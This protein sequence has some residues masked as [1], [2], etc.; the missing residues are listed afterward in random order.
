M[1]I[2]SGV[3]VPVALAKTL[4][5]WRRGVVTALAIWS[6]SLA[7]VATAGV[8]VSSDAQV[9]SSS[10]A[11]ALRDGVLVVLV[12][13]FACSLVMLGR[14][15]RRRVG[16]EQELAV[17]RD[18]HTSLLDMLPFPVS[19]GDEQGRY[20]HVNAAT[21]RLFGLA[22]EQM[23]GRTQ[24]ECLSVSGSKG[25]LVPDAGSL[26]QRN[27]QYGGVR[28]DFTGP[29]GVVHNG[30]H[31]LQPFAGRPGRNAGVI[32]TVI[33]ITDAIE[34][35]R[36]AQEA[37][38]QLGDVTRNL[39][40]IVFQM[41]RSADGTLSY[42]YVGGNLGMLP[43]ATLTFLGPNPARIDEYIY[44][45]DAALLGSAIAESARSL[46]PL[47]EEF[48]LGNS[49][50]RWLKVHAVPRRERDGSILWNGYWIDIT[51]ERRRR[52]ELAAARDEAEAAGHARERFLALMSHEI[53][54]P[55]SGVLGL[56][57]IL[58][59]EDLHGKQVAT[60]G[61][62]HESAK[63]LLQILDDILDYSKIQAGKLQ[64]EDEPFDLRDICDLTL[65]LL[66]NRAHDKGLALRSRIAADIAAKV[67]GD[68]ARLR[69]ILLNIVGN[70][71]KF[72]QRGS[73]CLSVD[74][75]TDFTDRQCIAISIRDT[76]I[77]IDAEAI[78]T[79]FSPFV[80]AETST[81]RRFGGT[82]LGLAI[83]RALA[84]RMG[85]TLE[86]ASEPGQGT[87][88]TIR[89][90][91]AVESRKP[92]D[93]ALA[94]VRAAVL[95]DEA[96][97]TRDVCDGLLALGVQPLM[98][99]V[100][101]VGGREAASGCEI[102]LLEEGAYLPPS[103][104]NI[105]TVHVT[106]RPIATGYEFSNDHVSVSVNPLSIRALRAAC[107]AALG[108][109]A[110]GR[111]DSRLDDVGHNR[112][113]A[114][115]RTPE[116]AEAD[117]ALILVADDNL[118]NRTLIQGQLQTLGCTCIAVANGAEALAAYRK[119]RYALLITDFNMPEMDGY[120]LTQAIRGIEHTDASRG[121]LPIVG[122]TASTED[123]EYR[124]GLDAGMDDWLCKPVQLETL[125]SCLRKW[126][127][128]CFPVDAGASMADAKIEAEAGQSDARSRGQIHAT[129]NE[130]PQLDLTAL[131][132]MAGSEEA[133]QNMLA[134]FTGSVV[135]EIGD[136]RALLDTGNIQGLR[137]WTHKM[138]GSALAL[139]YEPLLVAL[140]EFRG[141]LT[142]DQG[143]AL[144]QA[145]EALIERL[146]G[147]AH[148]M[149]QSTG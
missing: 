49:N 53:R 112:L 91:L 22:P 119:N 92:E 105:P 28:I 21:G 40:A 24:Q 126:A 71:I 16:A 99:D 74:V 124:R 131:R 100:T 90:T 77:G 2:T 7:W 144:Q 20:V 110:D 35:E 60:V 82:G 23:L 108:Y 1:E 104:S 38:S 72:T 26:R 73:V 4:R 62:I 5:R 69:Q 87:T 113:A 10:P 34:A 42:P 18:F 55:M 61:M 132:R 147:I 48:R 135:G 138:T 121:R 141:A 36:E 75:E 13:L 130:L 44:K 107:R 129:G 57:E 70:A 80:Q 111:G 25:F 79:L 125:G 56:I 67:R 148:V 95:L 52:D 47:A 136:L 43:D 120:G 86:L 45:D 118:I 39:P 96:P 6:M 68:G 109:P 14:E 146:D 134:S 93:T 103:L 127:P 32:G 64:I 3:C 12:L 27:E 59:Q 98:T 41:H 63:A 58:A 15:R 66:A 78:R 46:Q 115:P 83:C 149:A 29:D 97:L 19:I 31:W 122:I 76:G 137:R 123:V 140:S 117:Q 54:T 94:G 81:S 145:G 17:E 114:A 88:V 51:D 65:G 133:L 128:G 85:G 142:G 89:L 50:E 8:L 139:Q 33:D 101:K 143:P 116:Q 37:K 11:A 106:G 30:L 102:A 84:T 9:Q